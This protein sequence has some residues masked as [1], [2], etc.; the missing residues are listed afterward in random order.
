MQNPVR[1]SNPRYTR[2]TTTSRQV[3]AV[4]A[5]LTVVG[6]VSIRASP[7]PASTQQ[8]SL[9]QLSRAEQRWRGSKVETYEFRFQY[10]GGMIPPPPPSVPPIL[11]RVADGKSTLLRPG[12]VPMPD[13]LAQYSTVEKLF[14]FV[15][16]AWTNRPFRVDVQ[17]DQALGYP[18][19]VRV[20]PQA[21]VTDIDFG[22]A[23]SDFRAEV[24]RRLGPPQG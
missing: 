12:P 15:R 2:T 20:Y 13:D 11:F 3:A 14:A 5:V 9:D 21:N 17:Y 24:L 7:H 4:L 16:K 6:S 10:E 23:I 18:I 22:F 8:D 1:A 19:R